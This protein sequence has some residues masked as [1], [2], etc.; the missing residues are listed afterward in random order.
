MELGLIFGNQVKAT[1]VNG[2]KVN[3]KVTEFTQEN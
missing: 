1:K 3:V 2:Y